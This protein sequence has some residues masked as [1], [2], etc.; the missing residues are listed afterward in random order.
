MK[1]YHSFI[2]LFLVVFL[3]V[4]VFASSQWVDFYEGKMGNMS[5]YKKVTTKNG[6]TRCV[7]REVFSDKSREIFLQNRKEK[8]FST[9]GYE[10]LSNSQ[11]L[12]EIDCQKK[13][14][15]NIS[16]FYFD[17]DGKMLHSA[18]VSQPKWVK[19]PNDAFFNALLK[20]ICQQPVSPQ[21]PLN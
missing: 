18:F 14:I 16:V 19:V 15:M 11:S 2:F 1:R 7:V 8:S 3:A 4:P 12:N 21:Q 10:K 13:E 5:A 6:V 20:E 17:S 9:E